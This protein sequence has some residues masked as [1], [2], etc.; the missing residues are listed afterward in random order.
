ME[1]PRKE[2]RTHRVVIF[3]F[4]STLSEPQY[5]ARHKA[6]AIADKPQLLDTLSTEERIANFGGRH[7]VDALDALLGSLLASNA[8]VYIVSL[9]FKCAIVPQLETVGLLR[10]FDQS[11][12]Y[13]QDSDA[14]R[15]V[16]YVKADLIALLV[17]ANC[18]RAAD[19]LFV[20]EPIV[21]SP[22]VGT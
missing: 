2:K 1:T 19:V 12:I 16:H 13:G 11:R 5:V 3:D 21:Y 4:D 18:W 14:L 9:G 20:S 6:W 8:E 15:G 7:R 10:H 22:T 17:E